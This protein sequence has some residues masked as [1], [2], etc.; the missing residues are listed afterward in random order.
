MT[1]NSNGG[2]DDGARNGSGSGGE[3]P[4]SS[5]ANTLYKGWILT[6]QTS[7]PGGK[8]E[9]I[10]IADSSCKWQAKFACVS[11]QDKIILLYDYEA[12]NETIA[13]NLSAICGAN[14]SAASDSVTYRL[15]NGV[16]R[17]LFVNYWKARLSRF[18][19]SGYLVDRTPD[20]A[21]HHHHYNPSLGMINGAP[22]NY[23]GNHHLSNRDI[24]NH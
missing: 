10:N 8:S 5:S 12:N 2:D 24:D 6:Y 4:T 11:K 3:T 22:F 23:S 15:D 14:C 16:K 19:P 20:E 7:L 1:L 18:E 17:E 9:N 13:A 21:N